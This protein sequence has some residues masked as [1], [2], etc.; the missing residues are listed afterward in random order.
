M[1]RVIRIILLSVLILSGCQKHAVETKKTEPK[2]DIESEHSIVNEK[3]PTL[4]LNSENFDRVVGWLSENEILYVT[5][6]QSQYQLHKY[7]LDSGDYKTILKIEEPILDVRIH[8]NLKEIAVVTSENS[9]SATI[10]LF[11]VTGESKDKLTI[12]SSEMYWDWHPVKSDRIFFSGFYEDWSFDSFF[13]SGTTKELTR[14][15]TT[16][17]FAKW[18]HDSVLF[19]LN[20]PENDSLSGGTIQEINV[21]TLDV[22]QTEESNVIH[23]ESSGAGML[24][25]TVSDNQE[26]F[27]YSLTRFSD[28]RTTTFELPAISNY[29]QWFVPEID[30]LNDGSILTFKASEVGLMDT[31]PTEYSLVHLSH[32]DKETTI[33]KGPYG[34]FACSPSG[35]NCLVGVQLEE[36]VNVKNDEVVRWIEI[37]EEFSD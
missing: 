14:I 1:L 9:L 34:V 22:Q 23:V 19:T 21:E 37:V 31:I 13:Y 18:G 11:A 5:R 30:W 25:I 24:K 7:E 29:S 10:H 4:T 36:L 8:P 6:Q 15:E 20:W 3:P 27:I 17:P 16:D 26:T 2:N 28:G 33:W 35:E 32:L 12:E